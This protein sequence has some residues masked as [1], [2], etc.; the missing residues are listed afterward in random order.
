MIIVPTLVL[1]CL[2]WL[3][4]RNEDTLSYWENIGKTFSPGDEDFEER[5]AEWTRYSH[6]YMANRPW[7]PLRSFFEDTEILRR[8]E[9]K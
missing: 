7:K 5:F 9:S 3:L 1:A 2:L 6:D 4:K 8:F